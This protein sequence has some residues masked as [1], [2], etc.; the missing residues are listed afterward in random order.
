MNVQRSSQM[1]E[2]AIDIHGSEG[3]SRPWVGLPDVDASCRVVMCLQITFI[4]LSSL[5]LVTVG[6]RNPNESGREDE[7]LCFLQLQQNWIFRSSTI[8]RV[9]RVD[10]WDLQPLASAVSTRSHQFAVSLVRRAA[11][12][13]DG[14]TISQ[15]GAAR[16]PQV[17]LL[18]L[19]PSNPPLF[20]SSRLPFHTDVNKSVRCVLNV[21]REASTKGHPCCL[22][23][24]IFRP[25]RA[26]RV[27]VAWH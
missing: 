7:N 27:S 8:L 14:C 24:Q 17:S 11:R 16:M 12:V 6:L 1:P 10:L 18:V 9:D 13:S 3:A 25:V 15:L 21:A 4:D 19:K 20:I 5:L 2:K 22:A 23:M 26:S